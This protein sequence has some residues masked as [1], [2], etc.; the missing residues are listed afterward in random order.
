MGQL[1]VSRVL[2]ESMR[3][4]AHALLARQAS[5]V[6][7]WVRAALRNVFS[8]RLGGR[9]AAMNPLALTWYAEYVLVDHIHLRMAPIAQNARRAD[10]RVILDSMSA[11]FARQVLWL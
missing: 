4:T 9:L 11:R 7:L 6:S 1:P 8:A 5:G 3:G 2:L 10:F